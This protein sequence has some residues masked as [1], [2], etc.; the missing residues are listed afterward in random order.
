M[1]KQQPDVDE[2]KV[3]SPKAPQRKEDETKQKKRARAKKTRTVPTLNTFFKEWLRNYAVV[4]NRPSEQDS[5]AS[6]VRC[7]LGP[8]LG[9][10]K[11]DAICLRDIDRYKAGKLEAGFSPKTVNNH[12]TVLRRALTTAVEY[13][14]I[15]AFPRIKALPTRP[16]VTDFLDF[17][18]AERLFAATPPEHRALVG[19]ALWTGLRRGELI[20]LRWEDV[21]LTAGKVHVRRS[22]YRDTEGPPK[23]RRNRE[24]PICR[25]LRVEL[26]AHRHQQSDYVFCKHKGLPLARQNMWELLDE[27]CRKAQ[28]RHFGWHSLRHTFAS[29]M[30]MKGVPL[31]AVQ[32]LL[33]HASIEMTMRYAHLAPATL[34]EAVGVFDEAA[35]QLNGDSFG[36][37]LG[38]RREF[39]CK[40]LKI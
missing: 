40:Q 11:L 6:I 27:I 24:V 4:N 28:L 9:S 1:A 14:Y 15:R 37:H 16:P 23:S 22:R 25:R 17:E 32:E 7:H 5:K 18:E 36:N 10:F 21:D 31:R 35:A 30:V 29:H 26:E 19:M 13:E 39:S 8:Q 34:V 33:G 2:P 20:A 38:T 3:A 12:L